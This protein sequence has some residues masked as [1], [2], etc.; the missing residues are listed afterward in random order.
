[1]APSRDS[2]GASLQAGRKGDFGTRS[3]GRPSAADDLESGRHANR[4]DLRASSSV[5]AP[6]PGPI[7]TAH[8]AAEVIGTDRPHTGW[9]LA[10]HFLHSSSFFIPLHLRHG[11]SYSRS[12]HSLGRTGRLKVNVEPTPNSHFTHIRPPCSSTNFRHSVSPSPVPS[13]FFSES[14]RYT[15]RYRQRG[16]DFQTTPGP[17]RPAEVQ[18]IQPTAFLGVTRSRGRRA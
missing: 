11:P 8:R 2:R 7:A 17:R 3:S 9:L 18:L 10:N 6:N 5:M 16:Q 1:R 12:A 13:T 4:R 15:T 14:V